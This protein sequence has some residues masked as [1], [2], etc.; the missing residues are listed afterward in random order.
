MSLLNYLAADLNNMLLEMTITCIFK[1]ESFPANRTEYTR[2]NDLQ[3]GGFLSSAAMTIT[4]AYNAI[5]QK[6]SIGDK[7]T[8][9]GRGFRVVSAELAQDAVSVDFALEDINR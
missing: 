2:G 3:D 8:I 1:G 7:I 4:A 5:T 9:N 6:V